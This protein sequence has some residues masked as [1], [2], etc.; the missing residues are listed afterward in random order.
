MTM[1]DAVKSISLF[2]SLLTAAS[3]GCR[4]AGKPFSLQNVLTG[5]MAPSPRQQV[6]MAFGHNDPDK[7]REGVVLLANN[8]WGL[9]EPCLAGYATLL[10]VDDNAMVRSTAVRAL[11]K[12]GEAKYLPDIV[13]CLSDVSAMVRWD[14]AVALDEVL[15]EA[16]IKPL[17]EHAVTDTSVDVRIAC[18][19]ALRHYRSGEVIYTLLEC[20]KDRAFGVRYQARTLLVELTGCDFGYK[21]DDWSVLAS[22]PL[23]PIR[24][25]PSK[26]PARPWWDFLG[27]TQKRTRSD[28]DSEPKAKAHV[29]T[30]AGESILPGKPTDKG[31]IQIGLA[32]PLPPT[33]LPVVEPQTEP[34][35]CPVNEK[36]YE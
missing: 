10:K 35:T 36:E 27:V 16:A 12:A 5:F 15:G 19:K 1:K 7:R 33:G 22:G 3:A 14:A 9:K 20:M 28:S 34:I 30:A 29:E 2:V 25:V 13:A 11:G 21:P 31:I 6:V 17:Q 4:E 24:P 26:R 23:P 8:S 18:I 32:E